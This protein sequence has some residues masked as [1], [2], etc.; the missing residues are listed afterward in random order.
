MTTTTVPTAAADPED[1][2]S[3]EHGPLTMT[4]SSGGG[5]DARPPVT[6]R[7]RRHV[8]PKKFAGYSVL[9]IFAVIYLYPFMTEIATSFKSDSQ[10]AAHGLS[11][12]PNPFDLTAWKRM[13][14]LSPDTSVPM[15]TW[16][17][18]SVLAT[19]VITASRVFFDSLAG[20][21]LSRL[22][23]RG[24]SCSPSCWP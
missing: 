4:A 24:R 9:I 18:N 12:I 11:L 16:L 23:F 2:A 17:G 8:S 1:S 21:A 13:F 5:D 22:H 14:G 3:P 20:Y 6:S 7:R 15:M 10:A 19:V